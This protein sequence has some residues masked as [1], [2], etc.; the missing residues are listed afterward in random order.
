MNIYAHVMDED[1]VLTSDAMGAYLQGA[2]FN[3]SENCSETDMPVPDNI[4]LLS[5]KV[6]NKIAKGL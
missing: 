6:E 5:Q 2:G 1:D 4:I 3:C